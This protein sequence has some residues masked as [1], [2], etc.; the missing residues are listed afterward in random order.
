MIAVN[1]RLNK[2]GKDISELGEHRRYRLEILDNGNIIYTKTG[3]NQ[4]SF[5]HFMLRSNAGLVDG[6]APEEEPEKEVK[7]NYV[8]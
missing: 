5:S 3:C 6:P 1:C 7:H 4:V 8:I 2:D